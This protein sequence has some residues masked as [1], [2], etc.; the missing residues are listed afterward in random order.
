MK[1]SIVLLWMSLLISIS[2]IGESY[3]QDKSTKITFIELGSVN[4]IHCKKMQPIMISLKKQIRR[5]VECVFYDVWKKK[6]R[7]KVKNSN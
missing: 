2:V 7:K 4:C 5:A 1:K 6:T 3:C